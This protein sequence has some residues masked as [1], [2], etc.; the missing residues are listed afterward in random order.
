MSI[1]CFFCLLFVAVLEFAISQRGMPTVAII[2]V[3]QFHNEVYPA[4]HYF[5]QSA[6][7]SV[8]TFAS[9]NRSLIGLTSKWKFDFE[10]ILKLPANVCEFRLLIF[11]SAEYASDFDLCYKLS[12]EKCLVPP[13]LLLVI[14][15]PSILKG[16][17]IRKSTAVQSIISNPNIEMIALGPHTAAEAESIIRQAG[18]NRSI[19]Y[20]IP[21]FNID[22][23]NNPESYSSFALQG[24]FSESRRNYKKIIRDIGEKNSSWPSD[25]KLRI[26]GN[27]KI[28]IPDT[29]KS[30]IS[31][32]RDV[33]Y[34]IYYQTIQQ[35]IG[36]LTA[37]A[38]DIYLVE[39]ASSTIAV[40]LICHV[41]LL[42]EKRTLKVY[43]YL[44]ESSV[45]LKN[46]NESN[47]EAMLRILNTENIHFEYRTRV[48]S[49][50]Q[51]VNK[52]YSR[53]MK[54]VQRI[55]KNI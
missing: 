49:L 6:G 8:Q 18:Q 3:A 47:A 10:N 30:F 38:S 32:H 33:S 45:W 40:S 50:I 22:S 9:G 28:N 21:F 11:T 15:N 12:L 31:I 39:K 19:D 29:A 24:A 52:A 2:N 41:P 27:G 37:F 51:D 4:F 44:S 1:T 25:F 7:Y 53:N 48:T 26:I 20:I 42:T 17:I 36:L 46:D 43:D 14:H 16:D 54:I 34:T 5:W 55:M 13:R 23:V 35:A